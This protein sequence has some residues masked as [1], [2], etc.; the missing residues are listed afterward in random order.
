MVQTREFPRSYTLFDFRCSTYHPIAY[1]EEPCKNPLHSQRGDH[2]VSSAAA[3]S[4]AM[5]T[6][7]FDHFPRSYLGTPPVKP[8]EEPPLLPPRR[9]SNRLRERSSGSSLSKLPEGT[10]SPRTSRVVDSPT[11][12]EVDGFQLPSPSQMAHT[13]SST[14]IPTTGGG[15]G[16]QGVVSTHAP[17]A[18]ASSSKQPDHGQEEGETPE[19][20]L[21]L[22][23]YTGAITLG[24]YGR[25]SEHTFK[26]ATTLSGLVQNLGDIKGEMKRKVREKVGL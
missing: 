19:S 4:Q 5:T 8:L 7:N 25:E 15:Y 21:Y 6:S 26:G 3:C 12:M 17:A 11:P 18:T 23:S 20:S 13:S 9:F 2:V 16:Q 24:L 14:F 10:S 1:H 22:S